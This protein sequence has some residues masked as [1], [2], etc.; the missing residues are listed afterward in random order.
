MSIDHFRFLAAAALVDGNLDKAEKLVLLKAAAEMDVSP[1]DA[2]ATL[3]KVAEGGD[4]SG[5]IPEDPG[6]RS[7]LFR[8][9]V[10]IVAADG[11]VDD[12]EM[13]FF[14]RLAPHFKLHEIEVEDILRAATKK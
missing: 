9:L 4:V 8:S 1:E 13:A 14:K 2:N 10:D 5:S 7:K 12:S 3:K 11:E 6:A